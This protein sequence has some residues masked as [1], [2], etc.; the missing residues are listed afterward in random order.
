MSKREKELIDVLIKLTSISEIENGGE[1]GIRTLGGLMGPRL[2]SSEFLSASQAP[3]H[4]QFPIILHSIN[5]C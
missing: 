4:K 2:V 3:L 1:G 5:I